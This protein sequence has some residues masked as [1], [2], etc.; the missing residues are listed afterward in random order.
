MQI[1]I[2]SWLNFDTPLVWC[3]IFGAPS[4]QPF[5][6]LY[7][8]FI[9]EIVKKS[10]LLASHTRSVQYLSA[11]HPPGWCHGCKIF[12]LTVLR[13]SSSLSCFLTESLQILSHFVV[14]SRSW[15]SQWLVSSSDFSI[16][17]MAAFL[18]VATDEVRFPNSPW[19]ARCSSYRRMMKREHI[20]YKGWDRFI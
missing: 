3:Q 9:H 13:A 2:H 14:R 5:W 1:Q 18:T 16:N 8:P 6:F 12:W 17:S 11:P 19:N 10:P 7:I 15:G 4:I 20:I